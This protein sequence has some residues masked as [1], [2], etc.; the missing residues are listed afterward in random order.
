MYAS[1][2]NLEMKKQK[3]KLEMPARNTQTLRT[4]D[5]LLECALCFPCVSG[6]A[7]GNWIILHSNTSVFTSKAM[8]I[9]AMVATRAQNSLSSNVHKNVSHYGASEPQ[10]SGRFE[11]TFFLTSAERFYPLAF[12]SYLLAFKLSL[13]KRSLPQIAESQMD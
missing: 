10:S 4:V 11:L 12:K 2:Q 7:P 3:R 9:L 5:L 6:M 1:C 8:Q 13:L